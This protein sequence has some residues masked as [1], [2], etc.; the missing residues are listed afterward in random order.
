MTW[1]EFYSVICQRTFTYFTFLILSML[2]ALQ[3]FSTL[4]E[5]R[6]LTFDL[7]FFLSSFIDSS[8][9]SFMLN[10]L[11]HMSEITTCEVHHLS[12]HRIFDVERF[13][14]LWTHCFVIFTFYSKISWE[15]SCDCLLWLFCDAVIRLK[16]FAL[17]T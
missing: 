10:S 5:S 8:L 11:C 3:I 6:N 14:F 2:K 7:L 13:C 16:L 1:V 12:D 4:F 9:F 15:C 17:K